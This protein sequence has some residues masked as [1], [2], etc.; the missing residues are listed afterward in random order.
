MVF[1]LSPK[2]TNLSPG[3]L[4]ATCV[5]A[6]LG[7]MFAGLVSPTLFRRLA[8]RQPFALMVPIVVRWKPLRRR[9]FQR[10]ADDLSDTVAD[11]RAKANDEVYAPIPL[12]ELPA[13]PRTKNVTNQVW[14]IGKLA[15]AL[16]S[17]T[18]DGAAPHVVLEAPGGRGKSAAMHALVDELLARWRIDPVQPLPVLCW[19]PGATLTD[20]VKSAF[21]DNFLTQEYLSAQLESGE[22]IVCIDGLT[23]APVERSSFQTHVYAK[24]NSRVCVAI[25]PSEEIRQLFPMTKGA[26]LFVE[27]MILDE[28]RL[29]IFLGTYLRSVPN[30][31][32]RSGDVARLR[33]RLLPLRNRDGSY[34]PVIVRLAM[35]QEGE[36]STICEL[37]D[38]SVARLV[39]PLGATAQDRDELVDYARTLARDTY[40]KERRRVF[41]AERATPKETAMAD[42]LLASGL[43][44]GVGGART[45]VGPIRYRQLRFFHDSMQSYLAAVSLALAGERSVLMAAA[46][47]AQFREARAELLGASGPELFQMCV[48]TF[49]ERAPIEAWLEEQLQAWI[50]RAATAWNDRNHVPIELG[51]LQAALPPD[52]VKAVAS[53]FQ[54]IPSG[55]EFLRALLNFHESSNSAPMQRRNILACAYAALAPAFQPR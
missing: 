20:R 48:L 23:E 11:L 52:I 18:Q 47:T 35:F 46:S 25:R 30:D 8:S 41:P 17:R 1:T 34:L 40:W 50:I 22:L 36:G 4:V 3:P 55:V 5:A 51:V 21:G 42:R 19:K 31:V 14:S 39:R 12:A 53:E 2:Y 16:V 49:D 37:Y 26:T 54:T 27:P 6:L 45:G 38:A 28:E 15:D 33:R 29:G 32:T 9:V 44:V 43:L 7:A 13:S 24:Q 10:Y